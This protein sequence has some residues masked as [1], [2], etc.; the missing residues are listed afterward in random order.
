MMVAASCA[1]SD[2]SMHCIRLWAEDRRSSFRG[3][4]VSRSAPL[5]AARSQSRSVILLGGAGSRSWTSAEGV[6]RGYTALCMLAFRRGAS[7]RAVAPMNAGPLL[8]VDGELG[9][10]RRKIAAGSGDL[11]PGALAD[12][13]MRNQ[14][15][16]LQASQRVPQ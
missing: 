4:S 14:S 9:D 5:V 7:A 3:I 10:D 8:E 1:A 13:R 16:G 15:L 12:L 11:V 2:D 6:P